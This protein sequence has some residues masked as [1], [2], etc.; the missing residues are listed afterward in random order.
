[1]FIHGVGSHELLH[2][3][4]FALELRLNLISTKSLC[5]ENNFLILFIR[6]KALKTYFMIDTN[7]HIS[8]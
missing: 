2:D 8:S 7:L 4:S 6:N 1:M 5:I 3:V